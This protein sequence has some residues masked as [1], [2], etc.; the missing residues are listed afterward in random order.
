MH[1]VHMQS[2]VGD[3]ATSCRAT[4][5]QVCHIIQTLGLVQ[6]TVIP[7]VPNPLVGQ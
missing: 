1:V 3:L 5:A 7:V 6:R 4:T 2:R